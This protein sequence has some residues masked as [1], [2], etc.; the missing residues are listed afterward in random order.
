M[1][2]SNGRQIHGR[3]LLLLP[4]AGERERKEEEGEEKPRDIQ[5]FSG[6]LCKHSLALKK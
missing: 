5:A 4:H 1:P 6:L 2:H 3:Q